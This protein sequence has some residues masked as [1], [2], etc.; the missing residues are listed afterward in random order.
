MAEKI[1]MF[2]RKKNSQKKD[3]SGGSIS[4]GQRYN[5]IREEENKRYLKELLSRRRPSA[6]QQRLVRVIQHEKDLLKKISI[7][8]NVDARGVDA[9][10]LIEQRIRLVDNRQARKSSSA[11]RK[12]RYELPGEQLY[13]SSSSSGVV[14]RGKPGFFRFLVTDFRKISI[15]GRLHLLLKSRF[16]RARHE[17]TD[18]FM[19]FW[20]VELKVMLNFLD[21]PLRFFLREGW[22]VSSPLQYNLA[23]RLKRLIRIYREGML[24]ILDKKTVTPIIFLGG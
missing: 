19:R 3:D 12:Y 7:V 24:L 5:L 16:S 15:F 4:Q 22:K 2:L 17:F 9:L 6:V 8:E 23:V 21:E 13:S 18:E 20:N 14:E 11:E 10:E 1:N